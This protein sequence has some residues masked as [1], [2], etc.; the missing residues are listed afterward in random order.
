MVGVDL[1]DPQSAGDPN[2]L[3]RARWM[4]ERLGHE[5]RAEFIEQDVFQ[6]QGRFD[7]GICAGGLYHLSNP[8][9]LLEKLTEHVD[10]AL[11]VQTVHSLAYEDD[12]YF[13]QPAPGW[14]WGCRFSLGYLHRMV[15]E[16]GWRVL[17]STE[18]V[19]EGNSRPDDRGS[20]Y[21]LAERA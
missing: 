11:V 7:F 18:N 1:G 21:I 9:A 19:L 2:N 12:G 4:S 14:T 15:K 20:A 13:E 6:I 16:S 10:R 8:Q 5:G 17:E 3:D